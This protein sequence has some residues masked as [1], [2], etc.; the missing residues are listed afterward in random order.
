MTARMISETALAL[1]LDH[2]KLHDLGKQG[3]VL[4]A[5]TVGANIIAE[6]LEKYGSFEITTDRFSEDK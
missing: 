3:G 1:V 2:D 5:A 6:R 4:T